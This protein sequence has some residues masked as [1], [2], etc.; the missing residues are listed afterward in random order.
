MSQEIENTGD[1]IL[2]IID[3]EGGIIDQDSMPDLSDE[4]L[5][6]AYKLM[7]FVRTADLKAF[8]YQRQGRLSLYAP[9]LGQEA[10]GVGAGMAMEEEDW[11]VPA[12][13]ELGAWLQK[14]VRL[15]E[16][17]LY[18]MGVED[19]CVYQNAHRVLPISVPIASQVL[20]GVGI[21]R[22]LQYRETPGVVFVF[23][24][25]GATSQGDFHEGMNFAGVWKAPVV[26]FCQNNQYAISLPRREQTASP[27]I[28]G[29][30]SAYG[31]P[32]IQVDGNDLLAVYAATHSAA[33]HA[34]EGKGPVLIEAVTYRMGAHTTSDDPSR[35]RTPE[36]EE[37]WKIR[38]PIL[39]MKKHLMGRGLWDE[40]EDE[41]TIELYKSQ[42]D[43][44][45]EQAL[46]R[47]VY[48]PEDVFRH[49]F[50]QM[51]Q[52]LKDQLREYERYLGW[53]EASR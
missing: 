50:R 24:G 22:A 13:R 30:A 49:Q 10:S 31:M 34:R 12:Y 8:S 4:K 28:A 16:V 33:S 5:V 46:S 43:E 38:D 20:H 48:E 37:E 19:G 25:D 53:K 6:E 17:F 39:R 35:Y 26:F 36:E 40:K 2:R 41:A 47:G 7:L 32:G 45:F 9:N 18:W 23:F 1:D 3:G 11:L 52:L 27:T 29:K 21:A 42:I 15:E 14:G 51:P 44:T